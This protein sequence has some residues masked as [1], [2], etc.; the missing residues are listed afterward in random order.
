MNY[1]SD[2]DSF[3][4]DSDSSIYFDDG[5]LRVYKLDGLSHIIATSSDIIYTLC[6]NVNADIADIDLPNSLLA[7]KFGYKFNKSINGIRWPESITD[8]TFGICFNR[9]INDVKWPVNLNVLKFGEY[10]DQAIISWPKTLT[11]ISFGYQYSQ[12]ISNVER[13]P[14]LT[15]LHL[16]TR[17]MI[18]LPLNGSPRTLCTSRNNY[19]NFDFSETMHIDTLYAPD[20][21]C[22]ALDDTFNAPDDTFNV[23]KSPHK[24]IALNFT[25]L[26]ND[27]I[28]DIYFPET[29]YKIS[30]R[31][32][33]NRSLNNTRFP[34]S[35]IEL[36]LSQRYNHDIAFISKLPN[37]TVLSLGRSFD[38]PINHVKFHVIDTINDHSNKITIDSNDFPKSL[39]LIQRY[40]VF[41]NLSTSYVYYS[42]HVGQFTK[43]A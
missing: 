40:K 10:F 4:S 19:P 11:V 25:Y 34:V 31:G 20:D 32:I 16:N 36:N 14:N 27:I 6:I 18:S 1:S 17:C 15:K 37:L 8:I 26:F 42:R 13:P 22:N 7:I 30:F 28:D 3:S 24:S 23:L 43:M 2:L 35:L 33:F 38:Q 41:L 9:C 29:I 21:T 5:C 39:R 12:D